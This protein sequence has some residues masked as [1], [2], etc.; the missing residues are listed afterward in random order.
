MSRL[1]T[2]FIN[3]EDKKLC[4]KWAHYFPIYE[5]HFSKWQ[6]RTLFFLEIGVFEGGSGPIWSK[7]FGPLATVVGIDIDPRCKSY[8]TEYFKVKIGDQSDHK[9]LQEIIDEF[10][11]P[12][13]VLDDGSHM[14]NHV[15]ETFR[16]LYPK[17]GLNSVYMVEDMHAAYW[18][19]WGGS[20]TDPQTFVNRSKAYVD[21]LYVHHDKRIEPDPLLKDTFSINFYDSIVVYEKG[22]P[23]MR[24]WIN[25]GK[26]N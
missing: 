13:V 14:M 12:D 23:F 24:K 15:W 26:F 4:T 3:N 19:K 8:E 20:R 21:Q 2:D 10:G 7:Y 25:S 6:D 18:E 1:W 11:V 5:R 9:F 22:R 17:M 16:F